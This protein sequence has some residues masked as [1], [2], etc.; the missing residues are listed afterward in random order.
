MGGYRQQSGNLVASA[1]MQAVQ[2]MVNK[3]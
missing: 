1:L 3:K 2:G